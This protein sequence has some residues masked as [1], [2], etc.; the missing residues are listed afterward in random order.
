MIVDNILR[1]IY[2]RRFVY[3]LIGTLSTY[4]TIRF[5]YFLRYRQQKF[6]LFKYYGIPGPEPSLI[7]GNLDSYRRDDAKY[8]FKVDMEFKKKYGKIFGYFI[9]DEPSVVVSDLNM[10]RAIFLDDKEEAMTERQFVFIE[11]PIIHSVLFAK[12][13]RWKAMRK[14]LAPHFNKYTS[15]GQSSSE[16]VEDTVRLL[17]DY[18]E[19]RFEHA[20]QRNTIELDV[21][22]LMKATTL[23]LISSMAVRLPNTKISD[24]E[25]N[26]KSLDEYLS[27]CDKGIVVWAIKLPFLRP[28]LQV[29]ADNF[30]HN[31]TMKLVRSSLKKTIADGLL[32]LKNGEET[33]NQVID[34]MIKLHHDGLLTE[35]EVM[36]NAEALLLA[37][38]DTTATTLS[39]L[40]WVLAKYQTVQEKLRFEL[41]AH[42][43]DSEYLS[44]VIN[45]T[46]RLY[47]VVTTF[48]T[49]LSS[50]TI[51][52]DGYT[53][54]KGV[55]V[56]YNSWLMNHDPS[57]WDE[58]EKFDPDR[59]GGGKTI[60]PCAFAP[61]G[62]GER[63]CL[64]F[65]L[66]MLELKMITCDMLL[67]YKLS[68][69][70]PETLDLIGYASVLTKPS[71]K[72]IL[73]LAHFDLATTI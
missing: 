18:I 1:Y 67:R 62:L 37:G 14:I 26:V 22:G 36:G 39:Y 72:I 30:E 8:F 54:P 69:K 66:A 16:F 9:G 7:G 4:L 12:Y 10:L 2:D 28:I 70:S 27:M 15:R 40:F 65:Q 47:P 33:N 48:T 61:F 29:L 49:R 41:I 38:Y 59:F 17:I 11:S 3:Q 60:H 20:T 24:R 51:E 57:L 53:I 25:E 64:G 13:H 71:E 6:R 50:K 5:V 34:V 23:H 52:V 56:V 45:E 55:R 44:Q 42:G 73:E 63:K 19:N 68:L 35:L 58:P 43:T 31:K 21:F 32:K 46:M